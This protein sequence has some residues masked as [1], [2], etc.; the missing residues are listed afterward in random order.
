NRFQEVKSFVE[1]G[2]EDI[3]I[4][5]ES[6]AWGISVPNDEHQKIYVWID[7]LINY[8]SA[9]GIDWWESHPAD[10]HVVGKNITRFHA[11]IW[12]AMLLSAGLPLPHQVIANGFITVDG[13][14]MGKSLG[15]G[16]DPLDLSARYGVD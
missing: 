16:V 14:K 2:L 12:P 5:R 6:R 10:I 8:I 13:T 11:V 3:S 15:N 4:S 1:Q 9:V 7:A